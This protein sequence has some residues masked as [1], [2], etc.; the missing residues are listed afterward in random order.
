MN[1]KNHIKLRK[2]LI[3]ECDLKAVLS[4][5]N[6]SFKHAGVSTVVLFFSKQD[7]VHTYEIK[8]YEAVDE[9]KNY[10]L[11][12][13]ADYDSI[14]ENSYSLN[15]K[16]Y[17]P[18][19]ERKSIGNVA[20]KT[21]GKICTM[22]P[23]S[24]RNANHGKKEGLYP[25]YTSSQTCSTYC[26]EYDYDGEYLIIGDGGIA[27]IKYSN[28]FSC[29]SHNFVIKI[30]DSGIITKYL[31]YY[32]LVNIELLQ[33]GF[34]GAGIQNISKDYISNIEV[35]V[36]SLEHQQEIIKDCEVFEESK[37]LSNL[38]IENIKK[39]IDIYNR[40][41]IKTLFETETY[42][43]EETENKENKAELKSL[44]DVCDIRI[45]F[46]PSTRDNS[47]YDTNGYTWISIADMTSF[48]VGDSDKKI[49]NKAIEGKSN[50]LVKK[51]SVLLSFKLSI[52]K[53]AIADCD[54]YTN[55]AIAS[56]NSNDNNILLNKYIAYYLS[57][58]NFKNMSNGCIGAG[59][60]NKEN[61]SNIQIPIPS[62]EHQKEII[63]LY[64]EKQQEIKKYYDKISQLENYI[65]E[66][67]QLQKLLF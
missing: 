35:P 3:E 52:G 39:I 62:L 22:L 7:D 11:L 25:F 17:M 57:L 4:V 63:R 12:C 31:Y 15:Y 49:S 42:N 51:G 53:V 24:K 48:Y 44:S 61:L 56:I 23:K 21:L 20:I 14:S 65:T 37:R 19:E 46:T 47:L 58:M 33:K 66:L 10:K 16:T 59:N 32:L 6:G 5:P 34:I 45:G 8:F 54:L 38:Q 36:P 27:N 1:S 2:Y 29:S 55:E 28:K 9:C 26:D 67:N 40:T 41:Q 50:K 18:K 43:G 60:L 64:E 30:I 13:I